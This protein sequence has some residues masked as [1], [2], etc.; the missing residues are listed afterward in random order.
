MSRVKLFCIDKRSLLQSGDE[1]FPEKGFT[2]QISKVELG[3]NACTKVAP[4][5]A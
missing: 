3:K 4:T 5:L 1:E 2:F